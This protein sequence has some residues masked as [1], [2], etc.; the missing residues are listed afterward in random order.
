MSRGPRIGRGIGTYQDNPASSQLS[1]AT[2]ELL[3]VPEAEEVGRVSRDAVTRL[4]KD[5]P[6]PPWETDPSSALHDSDARKFVECPE[7]VTLRWLNPKLVSQTGM[8]DWQAVPAK[9]SPDFK[10]KLRALAAPDNTIRRGDH[11]GD[12]LAWMYTRWVESRTRVKADY[13]A[14]K[15]ASASEKFRQAQEAYDS[16]KFGPYI[17]GDGGRHPT[18]TQADGR[19]MERG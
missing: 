3:H 11:S 5:V 9:G 10:L 6:P 17:R 14:K 16:G 15:T 7:N 2:E 4:I 19:T 13:T 12:F 18:H 8:R 1:S